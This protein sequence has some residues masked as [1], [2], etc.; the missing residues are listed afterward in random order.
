MKTAA[1]E[2]AQAYADAGIVGD[3]V[4]LEMIDVRSHVLVKHGTFL[5]LFL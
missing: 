5:V 3:Y 1:V 2:K 4:F